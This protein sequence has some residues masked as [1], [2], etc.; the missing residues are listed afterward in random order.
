[1]PN[2]FTV[3]EVEDLYMYA[4]ENGV[5][6]ITIYRDGCARSGILFTEQSNK[7]KIQ[8]LK[9]ELDR[10]VVKALTSNPEECPMCGGHMVHAGGYE[11][12]QDCGYS[13]CA[14]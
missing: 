4:W 9:E 7:N 2:E 12:C 3:D 11:E 6:G 1:M 14:I 5:K 13:P 8:A 10:E